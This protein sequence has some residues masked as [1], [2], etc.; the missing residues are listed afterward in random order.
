MGVA[1]SRWFTGIVRSVAML[2]KTVTTTYASSAASSTATPPTP[3]AN[4]RRRGRARGG[5]RSGARVIASALRGTDGHRRVD[6]RHVDGHG[7]LFVCR[8]ARNVQYG[9]EE[10][11][12]LRV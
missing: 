7:A 3:M 6:V 5:I 9:L 11:L 2:T 1:R 8:G 10:L 12:G 4:P